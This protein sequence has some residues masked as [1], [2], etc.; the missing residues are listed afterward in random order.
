MRQTSPTGVQYRIQSGDHAAVVVEVGG[1]LRAY[2]VAGQEIIDAY[3]DHELP[4]A[5]AGM[6]LAPWPNR[7]RDGRYHWHGVDYQVALSE[8][9]NGNAIHGLV[10]W[11]SWQAVSVTADAVTLR[12]ALNPQPGYPWRLE[13]TTT[14]S[15]GPDGLR[16]EHTVTNLADTPAPFGLGAH[17]YVL[18]PGTPADDAVLT[19]PADRRLVVD[20]RQLPVAAPLV[21]GTD[22]D[23]TQGRRIGATK[24]DTT[25]GGG[26]PG[27]AAILSTVDGARQ[28]IVW[29]D[30]A[31]HWWQVFTGDPLGPPRARRAVSIEPMT[32]PPDAFRS[33]REIITLEPGVAWRGAWGIRPE[34]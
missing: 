31:F 22:W 24:L 30:T 19:I 7:L 18:L 3:G 17:P 25:F 4:P 2:E 14:W 26:T 16:A 29:A 11:L 1:G 15:V 8:P 28:V 5:Y 12:C 33:G 27:G 21:A 20:G 32:C 10:C 34:L 9:E 6:V 13:L 23:Y